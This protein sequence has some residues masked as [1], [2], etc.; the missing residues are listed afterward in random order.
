MNLEQ[1][2]VTPRD[3]M[4]EWTVNNKAIHSQKGSKRNERAVIELHINVLH[5]KGWFVKAM[6][7]HG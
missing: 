1:G 7:R 5:V 4:T 2:K 3:K 6:D